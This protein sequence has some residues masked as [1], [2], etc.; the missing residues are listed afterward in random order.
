M[1]WRSIVR[2]LTA[3]CLLSAAA[4]SGEVTISNKYISVTGYDG[5][6]LGRY[7]IK[8]KEGDPKNK[9]DDNQYITFNDKPPS[10]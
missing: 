8:L 7:T 9:R 5:D 10:T 4:L 1:V 6:G 3:G 2:L